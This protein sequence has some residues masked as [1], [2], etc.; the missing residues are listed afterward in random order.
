MK[1]LLVAA[2]AVV[3]SNVAQ[4]CTPSAD[5]FNALASSSSHLTP[6][7]FA[8]LP[9]EDKDTVCETR[10]FIQKFE[11]QNEV[12]NGAEPYSLDYLSADE[13]ERTTRANRIYLKKMLEQG[14]FDKDKFLRNVK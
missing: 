5:D 12:M 13:V 10:A 14:K 2:S 11:A 7:G 4:A 1:L 9:Q 3:L 6:S 8:A